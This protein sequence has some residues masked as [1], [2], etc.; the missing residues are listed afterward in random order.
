MTSGGYENY[1][2]GEDG[3]TYWHKLTELA[4]L[5]TV[6]L[7]IFVIELRIPNLIPLPGVKLGL[8]NIITIFAIY[9]YKPGETAMIVFSRILMGSFFSG[10][11]M[12]MLYS[13]AGASLCL[14]GM[15]VLKKIIPERYLWM[16][17]VLGAVLHNV[18]Q[19]IV[20]CLIAGMGV[21]A[22]FPFL[23]VSGC[24]AGCFTGMCAQQVISRLG[25]CQSDSLGG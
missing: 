20:A 11:V 21:I 6:A 1:F 3:R 7:I 9:H 10:N 24:I 18:G 23:L 15:L 17:S 12:A 4:F 25:F 16:C 14:G 8:A 19:I 13:V 2:V 5:T 22:Y